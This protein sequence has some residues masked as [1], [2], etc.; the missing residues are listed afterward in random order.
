MRRAPYFFQ[1]EGLIAENKIKRVDNLLAVLEPVKI[2]VCWKKDDKEHQVEVDL[3]PGIVLHPRWREATKEEKEE[4][5]DLS[6]EELLARKVIRRNRKLLV[7]RIEQ[8]K[9]LRAAMRQTLRHIPATLVARQVKIG[10][11]EVFLA[12]DTYVIDDCITKLNELIADFSR[13]RKISSRLTENVIKRLTRIG[14]TLEENRGIYIKE[15]LVSIKNAEKWLKLMEVY[16][17]KIS[18]CY[19]RLG[20]LAMNLEELLRSGKLTLEKLVVIANEAYGIRNYLIAEILFNPY[21]E[22]IQ[23]PEFQSLRRIKEHAKKGREKT[24]FNSIKKAMAKLEAIA[25][26]EKP[27][28][29]ELKEKRAVIS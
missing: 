2:E 17:R 16:E 29:E 15:A 10:K 7:L 8:I 28:R 12:G 5:K 27:S 13:A 9:D 14:Q 18:Q 23:T 1:I 19:L 3:I 6:P 26:G 11:E 20:K 22:R 4:W 21:Y 24:V 25:I